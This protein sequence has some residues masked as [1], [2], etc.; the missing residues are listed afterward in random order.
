MTRAFARH[1]DALA[2]I[3]ADRD[4]EN[5][6]LTYRDLE[7]RSGG[8]AAWLAERG[9]GPGDRAAI[10]M[11]NQARWHVAA[12]AV[13]RRG[14]VLV[15][16]DFK[17]SAAEQVALLAHAKPKVVFAEWH[18]LRAQ[19][20]VAEFASL[21]I[22]D[23]VATDVPPGQEIARPAA[24]RATPFDETTG[25]GAPSATTRDAGAVPDE[26]APIS[27]PPT[28]ERAP[29]DVACLVYSSGTGGRPKGCQLTHGNYLAQFDALAQLHPLGPGT[30]YLS[31]LPTNHA[32]DFM[33]GFLGP[34]FR[35]ATVVHLRTLRPEFVRDA[36]PRYRITHMAL[37]PL[38]LKNLETGLRRRFDELPP[39]RRAVFEGLVRLN[40]ALSGGRPR[41]AI[42]RRL[43]RPVHDAFG[44]RLEALF[45]GGA[46]SA[47]DTLRFFHRLGIP[48]A[49]GYGLTEAG[50]AITLDRLD[51]PQPETVG[52]PLP[53]IELTIA[54]PGP[55]G[56]GEV[57]VRS[58]MIMR[59]Y[60]DDP[61]LTA[62][63]FAEGWLCTGDLGRLTEGGALQLVGRRK[64]M[65]V[66]EGGKNVYPED[67]EIAFAG[68]APDLC[69]FAAHWL[70]PGTARDE[71][72]VLVARPDPE[73]PSEDV[74]FAEI[75][76]RNRRLPEHQRAS[77]VLFWSEEFPRTASMKVKR[78]VLAE[79]LRERSAPDRMRP[80]A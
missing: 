35:G 72:L 20:G 29:E 18:L 14:G 42:A 76:T 57:R 19:G 3:E 7:A 59:G 54:D 75:E 53:G 64:N 8:L 2:H 25:A 4:R 49:N 24:A 17:L 30:R 51:P 67:V 56:I 62:E 61:E 60:L 38:V 28:V 31:I 1:G 65:I 41:P 40:V 36:F 44:G 23:V 69:L 16:L 39:L 66:T 47:P 46:Y 78:G 68:L 11:S 48:V 10:V 34:Y 32:I 9:F 33:V 70:W 55:D 6:R 15:P 12:A 58:P 77:A 27:V 21:G 73:R 5:G 13:F 79:Y 43:L 74:L 71:R 22:A 37:V 52:T 50:T 80:L 63:T 26:P 45:V